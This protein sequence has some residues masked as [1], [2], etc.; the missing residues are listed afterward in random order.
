MDGSLA[1]VYVL[2]GA[3]STADACGCQVFGVSETAAPLEK[4]LEEIAADRAKDQ[5]GKPPGLTCIESGS[6]HYE[7]TDMD[8]N[9]AQFYITGHDME[10]SGTLMG[11]M[12]G[13]TERA[14]RLGDIERHL[15]DM[16]EAGDI[17][18]WQYEY[19]A[20]KPEAAQEVLRLLGEREGCSAPCNATMDSAVREA[21]GG[22]V[23]DDDVLKFLW[24]KFADVPV[25][26]DGC[27]MGCFMGYDA[28]TDREE[29]WHWFD[30][31]HSEGVAAL[32][33]VTG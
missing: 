6:R 29:I 12:G 18:A 8:G 26:D 21:M 14:D 4:R 28:G 11:R 19:M 7:I 10:I 2:H 23:L 32:M 17:P 27:L 25:D 31:H 9:W 30:E 20:R 1:T 15:H 5:I 24:E 33:G 3:W 13:E 22:I 16:Y